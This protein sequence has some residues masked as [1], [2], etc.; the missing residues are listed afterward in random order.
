MLDLVQLRNGQLCVPQA[1][2][3]G[4]I[5]LRAGKLSESPL[6]VF[7]VLTFIVQIG[8]ERVCQLDLLHFEDADQPPL[9]VDADRLPGVPRHVYGITTFSVVCVGEGAC[10]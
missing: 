8:A 10:P 3:Y 7:Y 4:V 5:I 9:G 6:H 1:G 2:S